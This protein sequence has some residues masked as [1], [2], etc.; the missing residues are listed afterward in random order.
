GLFSETFY[1]DCHKALGERGIVIQQSESPLFHY[2]SIIQPMHKAMRDA[3]FADSVSLQ[4]PQ[5]CY[6][7]GWWTATMAGKHD[8]R[9]FRVT[10]AERKLFPT[11]Y[12]NAAIHQGALAQPEFFS[13]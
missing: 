7:S 4:F 10:D 5:P 9:R 8:M 1:R 6:P 3:G 2:R 13:D 11:R 12:Y